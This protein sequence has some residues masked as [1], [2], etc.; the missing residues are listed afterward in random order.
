M[1]RP[2]RVPAQLSE[3]L[4]KRLSAYTLAASAAGVGVLALAQPAGAKIVYTP[5]HT[6][7]PF[8]VPFYI[9]LNDDGKND[10]QFYNAVQDVGSFLAV[11]PVN[12]YNEVWGTGHYSAS[13]LRAGVRI[14]A[15][16]QHFQ[17]RH[18]IM[19]SVY[20]TSHRYNRQWVNVHRRYLGLKFFIDG[21]VHY[22]WA[23]L[24]VTVANRTIK[25]VLTGYAYE[26]IPNKP[27]ITGKTHGENEP[28]LGRL[29]QGAS[30]GSREKK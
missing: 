9:D 4:H 25:A 1:K 19:A 28:T 7:I 8:M 15:N 18:S 30:G 17:P 11:F 23:R 24:N 27:I 22:G 5:T 2:V 29:A 21:Q 26:T 3:S 13:A 12:S 20:G 14:R 10:F 16:T 6:K